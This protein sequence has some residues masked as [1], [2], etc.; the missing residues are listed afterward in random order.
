MAVNEPEIKKMEPLS[1]VAP[2][3]AVEEQPRLTPEEIE[4]EARRRAA[5]IIEEA[6]EQ[7]KQ[8]MSQAIK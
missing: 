8:I 1:E 7:K 5:E 4:E 3:I 2:E 6:E